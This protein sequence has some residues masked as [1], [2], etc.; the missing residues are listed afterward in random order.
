M[1]DM[2]QAAIEA[3]INTGATFADVRIE[4]TVTTI[5]EM[6]DGVTKRSIASRL[7]GAG[8]RAFIEGA[9]AFAQTTDLT[10]KGM[11]ETGESVAKLAI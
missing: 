6:T 3:A 2:A 9:W 11:R 8:I 7:K 4:N 1:E 10:T 5:I